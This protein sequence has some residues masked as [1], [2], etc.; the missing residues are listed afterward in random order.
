[1]GQITETAKIREE[2][3]GQKLEIINVNSKVKTE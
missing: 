3:W 2:I 1:M